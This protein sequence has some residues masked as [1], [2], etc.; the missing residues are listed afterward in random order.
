MRVAPAS[1]QATARLGQGKEQRKVAMDALFFK[2]LSRQDAFPGG[3]D[4]D[5]HTFPIN[6]LGFVE[7][8]QLA[9]FVDGGGGIERDTR[10]N[11]GRYA[12]RNDFEDFAAEIDDQVVND[13][14]G[15]GGAVEPVAF[16]VGDGFFEQVFILIHLHGGKNE[17]WIGGGVP[18]CKLLHGGKITGIGHYGGDFF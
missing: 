16:I 1:A 14:G 5:Q 8:N 6:A 2:F 15:K 7:A 10:V 18:R 11:L 4:F 17:G 3:G 13:F 12:A 9:G